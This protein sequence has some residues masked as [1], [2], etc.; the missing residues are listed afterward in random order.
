MRACVL[1]EGNGPRM[2]PLEG[3]RAPGPQRAAARVALGGGL[4][5]EERQRS[6]EAELR[7][8]D[9]HSRTGWC[10]LV[11]STKADVLSRADTERAL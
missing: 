4:L 9:S 1:R 5:L 10:V 2:Q 11:Q 8:L 6:L 3:A 7:H